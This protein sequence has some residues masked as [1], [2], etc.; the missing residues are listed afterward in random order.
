MDDAVLRQNVLDELEFE[1]SINAAHIGVTAENGVVTLSGHVGSYAEKVA[2]EHAAQRVKG[3]LGIAQEIAVRYGPLVKSSDDEIASR[4]VNILRWNTVVPKDAVQVKVENGW[5][6]LSGEVDWQFQRNT[7]E[8]DVRKLSGVSGVTNDIKIKAHVQ[9]TDVK[10]KIEDALKRNAEVEAHRI[11]VSVI[12]SGK[13]ALEGTV[14]NWQER[15]TAERA[16]WSAPGVVA[17]EDRLTVA[18]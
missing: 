15:S 13:I 6:R 11:R 2:A 1:P 7:A 5:I 16:A 17:V 12:G 14:H 8:S 10:R 9:T 18:G 3:V 4:A